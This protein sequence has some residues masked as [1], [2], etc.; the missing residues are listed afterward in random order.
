MKYVKPWVTVG[1]T[2]NPLCNSVLLVYSTVTRGGYFH[3]TCTWEVWIFFAPWCPL[4]FVKWKDSFVVQNPKSNQFFYKHFYWL[5]Q[6][7]LIFEK[8]RWSTKSRAI[9]TKIC[10]ICVIYFLYIFFIEHFLKN[11]AYFF[12]TTS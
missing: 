12:K 2:S 10:K 9:L 6:K 1:Y 8:L 7:Q 11:T 3:M 4:L 5:K